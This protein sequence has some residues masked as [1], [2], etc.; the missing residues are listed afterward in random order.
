[1]AY[2]TMDALQAMSADRGL[3]LRSLRADG[4]AAANGDDQVGP[5][6]FQGVAT[7]EV[8]V[9]QEDGL[10]EIKMSVEQDVEDGE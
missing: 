5:G 3:E 1:M 10:T 4:G 8:E 2:S 6:S 9:I 7:L